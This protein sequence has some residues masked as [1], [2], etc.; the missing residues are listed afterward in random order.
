VVHEQ[1]DDAVH[2]AG[3]CALTPP[4]PQLKGARYPGGFNPCTYHLEK[5]GFKILPFK[6]T[7]HRYNAVPAP[8]RGEADGGGLSVLHAVHPLRPPLRLL[9]K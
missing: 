4:D 3:R 2:A 5:T 6:F 1:G 8:R 9:K 7:L